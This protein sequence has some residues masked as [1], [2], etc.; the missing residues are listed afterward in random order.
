MYTY[1]ILTTSKK[2]HNSM[3]EKKSKALT[4]FLSSFHFFFLVWYALSE[5]DNKECHYFFSALG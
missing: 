1:M 3:H 4:E 5:R 2:K